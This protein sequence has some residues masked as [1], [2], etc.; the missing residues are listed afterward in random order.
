V[1]NRFQEMSEVV[2]EVK[3]CARE[4]E[5]PIIAL[6]QLSREVEKRPDAIPRLSDLR[7]TGEIEQTSDLVMFIHRPDYYEHSKDP[8][9]LTK[10]YIEKNRNGPTGVI[11]LTFLKNISKFHDSEQTAQPPQ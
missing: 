10:L 2:R 6:S 5:V 8:T 9:S 4:L 7:E 1:E 3:A 11:D